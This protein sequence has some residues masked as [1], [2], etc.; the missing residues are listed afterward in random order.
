[1]T[2][3]DTQDLWYDPARQC[4]AR[5]KATGTRCRAPAIRGGTVC[6]R[7]GG[8]A[9]QVR[10]K[11][12]ERLERQALDGEVGALLAELGVDDVHPLDALLD[13]VSQAHAMARLLGTL[14]A[15]LGPHPENGTAGLYGPDHLGDGRPHA[16]V[17]MHRR[18][19]EMAAR[20][21]KLA[22][23]AGVEARRVAL[24]ERMVT[25]MVDVVQTVVAGFAELLAK[26]GV[27]GHLLASV[28][29]EGMPDVYRRALAPL[30]DAEATEVD[31][32][33]G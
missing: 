19:V 23:D 12:R 31:G 16:L 15:G 1:M 8:A 18:W 11:A 28:Q 25:E 5:A 9:P 32:D 17:E 6:I 20:T 14:V 24:E 21:S 26:A 30:V 27:D 22:L 2:L 7:H 33:A 29:N 3:D 4:T 13:S 10:R